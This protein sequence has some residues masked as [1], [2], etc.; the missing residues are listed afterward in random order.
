MGFGNA[1]A[2]K[3]GL[4]RHECQKERRQTRSQTKA[5]TSIYGA[6][7]LEDGT[8]AHQG[9]GDFL[10]GREIG[11]ITAEINDLS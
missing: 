4:K 9:E 11:E 2:L 10:Y 7:P 1:S 5:Y 6:A 3:K 8:K